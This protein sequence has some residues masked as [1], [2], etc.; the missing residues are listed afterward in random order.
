MGSLFYS[1][2]A[3]EQ[4]RQVL[5]TAAN[6]IDKPGEWTKKTLT[7]LMVCGLPGQGK[8]EFV[9]QLGTEVTT[10]A[11]NH[12]KVVVV[13][14]NAVGRDINSSTDLN[15][16]IRM[17]KEEASRY[18]EKVYFNV[19]DEIDKA[20]FNFCNPFLSLLESPVLSERIAP[21]FWV[22]AQSQFSIFEDYKEYANRLEKKSLRDFLT[23]LQWGVVELPDLRFCPEQRL[24]SAIGIALRQFDKAKSI[25]KGWAAYFMTNYKIE[26]NRMLIKDVRGKS[27]ERNGILRLQNELA[28]HDMSLPFG[29]KRGDVWIRIR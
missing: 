7:A 6:Y 25:S 5:L 2:E 14:E 8:S 18:P 3:M 9:N 4:A 12:G 15:K 23:R 1:R 21:T 24:M 17:Q 28:I 13:N 16:V 10:L 22:F 11:S 26:N 29:A 19:F 27:L 20:D